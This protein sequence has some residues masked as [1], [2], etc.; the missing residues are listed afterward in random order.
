VPRGFPGNNP[1][2]SGKDREENQIH[3]P[4]PQFRTSNCSFD[5]IRVFSCCFVVR[6]KNLKPET[7]NS[8]KT[9]RIN[10]KP[11]R[12]PYFEYIFI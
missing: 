5:S 10:T 8:H 9:T 11:N 1:P 7:T 12:Y 3:F 2:Q 4:V 6:S